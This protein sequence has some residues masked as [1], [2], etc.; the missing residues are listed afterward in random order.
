VYDANKPIFEFTFPNSE[1]GEGPA[2]IIIPMESTEYSWDFARRLMLIPDNYADADSDWDGYGRSGI[3]LYQDDQ[4]WAEKFFGLYIKPDVD[5]TPADK[6]GA[7][8]ALDLSAS[9]I[10]LQG[11]S[12]NPQDPTMIKDTVG[13]Y[14]YFLDSDSEHNLSVNS[15]KHDYNRGL[16]GGVSE[17]SA[18]AFDASLPREERT[19]VSTCYVEGMGGPATEIYL[20]DDFL[21]ELVALETVESDNY[22]RMGINQCLL[23]LYVAGA[24]YD[25]NI[26]QSRAEE[27]TPMLNNSFARLGTYT[28]YATLAPVLD[29]DYV[30]ES[31]HD[32]EGIYNGYLDRSRGCYVLNITAHIQRLFNSMRTEDG[33]YDISKV[34]EGLRTMYIGAE[35]TSPYSLTESV[36]QGQDDGS[37]E[38]PIQIDLTYTL[39]K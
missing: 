36:F 31:Q 8:Y 1:L 29:Y 32:T 26:T 17:L 2:S 35:A 20:T 22:S 24:S 11:R 39:I 14:Y 12:R 23:T 33:G 10:M 30:Y 38:A 37:N 3:E 27:L 7:M 18:F 5:N 13:M 21:A 15:V 34:N 28:N 6:R 25:W 16:T 4:K 19:K 9:G